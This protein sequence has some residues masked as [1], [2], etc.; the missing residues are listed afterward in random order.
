MFPIPLP[1]RRK[2]VN[3]MEI[4]EIPILINMKTRLFIAAALAVALA[5]TGCKSNKKSMQSLYEQAVDQ[6]AA[7]A[8]TEVEP[9]TPAPPAKPTAPSV[10]I[11]DRTERVTPVNSAEADL[12]KNF[13]VVV[14][15]FGQ[16]T[17]AEGMK[18]KMDGRGY[19]AFIVKN[20]AG[21]YRVVA[22]GYDTRDSAESVRDAI[23]AAYPAEVGTCAEAWLLIP[24]R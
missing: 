8:V 1:S 7:T 5:V 21:M 10:P 23:R 3:A 17:N 16:M 4:A 19:K 2:N 13:N 11:K 18:R 12:L 22:G 6:D 20:E 15:S 14:G 24:Q 9:A